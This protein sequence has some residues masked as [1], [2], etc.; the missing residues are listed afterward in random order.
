MKQSS[1]TALF[2]AVFFKEEQDEEV[3]DKNICFFLCVHEEIIYRF[4]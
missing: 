3:N 4:E 2:L 1:R